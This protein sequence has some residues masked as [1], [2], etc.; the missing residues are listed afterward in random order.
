MLTVYE[1]DDHVFEALRSGAT[2]YVLKTTPPAEL[3]D[4]DPAAARGWL[5]DVERHRAPRR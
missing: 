5:T 1:D 3:L 2:G 4:A